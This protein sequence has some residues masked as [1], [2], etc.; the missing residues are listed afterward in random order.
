[1]ENKKQS[2]SGFSRDTVRNVFGKRFETILGYWYKSGKLW[3]NGNRT[4][5]AGIQGIRHRDG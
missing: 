3:L 2:D 1:M 5:R 4:V